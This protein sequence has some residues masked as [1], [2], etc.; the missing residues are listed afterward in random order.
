MKFSIPKLSVEKFS[1]KKFFFPIQKIGWRFIGFWPGSDSIASWQIA[2]AVCNALLV[3]IYAVFQ[4]MFCFAN[5]GDLVILLD[6]LLPCVAH[7]VSAIKALIII[8]KRKEIK[9]ILNSLEKSFCLSKEH[10]NK[11]S[12]FFTFNLFRFDEG[13]HQDSRQILSSFILLC[14]CTVC[15]YK[16]D[17]LFLLVI[18]CSQRYLQAVNRSRTKICVAV[19][20]F[21]RI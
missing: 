2:L 17:S 18:T 5:N 8:L 11:M 10:V 13:K 9:E 21:V 4:L 12:E 1:E 16:P 3:L 20:S 7:V 14:A 19:Q 6:A 15:D